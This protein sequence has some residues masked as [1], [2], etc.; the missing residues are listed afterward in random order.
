[1]SSEGL[2]A[3][4]VLT[5]RLVTMYATCGSSGESRAVFDSLESRNLYHWNA[6]ISGYSRNELWEEAM[7]AFTR[8]L[9]TTDLQPDGF[10]LPCVL[11]ACARVS[12]MEAGKRIHGV[13][14][15][16]GLDCDAFVCNSLISMYS[17]CGRIGE[18]LQLFDLMPQRNLVSWNTMLRGLSEVGLAEDCLHLFRQLL[19]SEEEEE[20]LH[21]DDATLVSVLPICAAEGV[22]NSLIDMYAKC[23][24]LVESQSLFR[25]LDQRNEVSWNTMIGGLSRSGEVRKTFELVREMAASTEEAMDEI[26]I[27]NASTACS[28]PAMIQ[29]LKEL[30]GYVIRNGIQSNDLLSNVL[31]AAYSKCGSSRTAEEI[32]FAMETKTVSSWNALMGGYAQNDD[33]QRAVDLHIQMVSSALRPDKFSVGSLLS[34]AARLRYLRGGRSSHGFILRNGFQDDSFIVVSL[35]SFYLQCGEVGSAEIIFNRMGERS[36]VAW[37]AMISGL[38]QNQLSG[39]ALCYFRR[40]LAEGRR[41]SAIAATGVLTACGQLMQVAGVPPDEVTL[42]IV[43]SACADLGALEHARWIGTYIDRESVPKTLELCNA[44]VNAL[45]KCGDIKG[46]VKLFDLMPQKSIVSW[47]SVID[48]LAMHGHG[49]EA[50]AVFERMKKSG[51][52]PDDVTFIGVLSACSHAGM[53]DEGCR[54]FAAMKEQHC[55]D[56]KIEHYGCMVDLFSR[57]GLLERAVSFIRSMPIEPNPIIWRTLVGGCRLHGHGGAGESLSMQLIAEEPAHSS[58]YVL[59]SNVYAVR[60]QYEKKFEVR[61]RMSEKGIRKVPGCSMLELGGEIHEF[62]AGDSSHPQHREIMAMVE[63]VDRRLRRAGYVPATAEVLLD[64]DEE[65]KEGALCRHS[66]RLAI[67]LRCCGRPPAR[68]S[69]W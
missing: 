36:S 69:G 25:E 21:P 55:I 23:G 67:A 32:F 15:K 35:L 54:Y 60:R 31:I 13:A 52:A 37:N 10:T 38:A 66:E 34:A 2:M 29:T 57:A 26:T 14:V 59:L 20:A 50:V 46:A 48:G 33:P 64:V 22:S 45:A 12:S 58:N 49:R 53:V 63:E 1:M 42:I 62:V 68:P 27:L 30:H 40:M 56:P 43:L 39:E 16:I 44:Q 3:D 61:R 51:V 5:T 4:S 8:M 41:P 9:F 24:R 65:D 17:R 11:R 7:E 18:A 19:L 28:E 47:T 6:L